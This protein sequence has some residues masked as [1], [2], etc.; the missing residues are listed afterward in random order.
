MFRP[1]AWSATLACLLG[2]GHAPAPS[3][4]KHDLPVE[5]VAPPPPDAGAVKIG[6][7]LA[8]TPP[9]AEVWIDGV[10]RGKAS[11]LGPVIEL[12][13]GLYTLVVARAGFSSFRVEFTV[14][15]KTESFAIHL[16]QKR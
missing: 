1:S 9:D 12:K 13:P 10:S 3:P 8:V 4:A 5:V 15:D 11:D 7:A 2:C 6:V 14:G 16:D